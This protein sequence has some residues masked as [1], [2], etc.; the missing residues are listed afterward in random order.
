M[1]L[2]LIGSPAFVQPLSRPSH[3][4]PSITFV[5]ALWFPAFS[6]KIPFGAE[7]RLRPAYREA[8][9]DLSCSWPFVD[10]YES[11]LFMLLVANCS[12]KLFIPR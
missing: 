7:V 6:S 10:Q 4:R 3:R 5:T 8:G 1:R 2:D 11:W 9:K 12:R